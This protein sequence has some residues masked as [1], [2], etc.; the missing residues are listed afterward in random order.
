MLIVNITIEIKADE[1]HISHPVHSDNCVLDAD[2]EGTCAKRAPAYTWRDYR[3]IL[4]P[5]NKSSH[6]NSFNSFILSLHF[7]VVKYSWKE[8]C[9]NLV[10]IPIEQWYYW[11]NI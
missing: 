2:G 9:D 5:N 1:E 10:Y 8:K 6:E 11:G 4:L 7:R 3:Y